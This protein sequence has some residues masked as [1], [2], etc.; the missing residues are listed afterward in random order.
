MNKP[1]GSFGEQLLR[2]MG[3][4]AETAAAR[5]ARLADRELRSRGN[6]AAAAKRLE[7]EVRRDPALL[8]EVLD[9][10]RFTSALVR[11]YVE[12]RARSQKIALRGEG[13][14]HSPRDD[15]QRL[16][17]PHEYQDAAPAA[18]G[19]HADV[20]THLRRAPALKPL[21]PNR[22]RRTGA[23]MAGAAAAGR[24]A[25]LDVL[26]VNGQPLRTVTAGEALAWSEKM[27]G[28]AALVARI[29][30]GL[31]ERV[32]VG[33]QIDDAEAERRAQT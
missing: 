27:A 8:L 26:R 1:I 12:R 11:R 25:L 2:A 32:P 20:V 33:D 15:H 3:R 7:A 17:R 6:V 5:L 28:D 4:A 22:P 30:R 10:A 19:G 9:E 16:A 23:A 31:Q 18:R 14:G 24:R 13:A 29:C 21:P